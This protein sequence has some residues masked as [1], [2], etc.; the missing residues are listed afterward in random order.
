M[1]K[2][3]L[4]IIGLLSFRLTISAIAALQYIILKLMGMLSILVQVFSHTKSSKLI[5]YIQNK[6]V[7][8]S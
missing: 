1:L 6:G 8:W 7:F 4:S 3:I 5:L 2:S